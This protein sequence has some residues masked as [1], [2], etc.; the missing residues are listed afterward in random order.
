[1]VTG[2]YPD[3]QTYHACSMMCVN[4]IV[5]LT[6]K[7]KGQIEMLGIADMERQAVEDTRA[8][9]WSSMVEWIGEERAMEIFGALDSG[10]IDRAIFAI[11]TALQASMQKQSA[12]GAVPF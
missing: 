3:G 6:A 2:K 12:R 4:A 7:G 1:M 11:W 10:Q 8:T 5:R 9:L